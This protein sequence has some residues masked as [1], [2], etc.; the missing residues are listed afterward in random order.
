MRVLLTNARLVTR[1]GSESYLHDV[2]RWLRDNGHVPIVYSASLGAMASLV[3][4]DRIAVVDDLA[5]VAE[6]PDVIHGQHHIATLTAMTFFASVPAVSFCH[7]WLPWEERPLRH[8]QIRRYVAV[9]DLTRE[10][11]V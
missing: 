7:G 2:A 10:R 1:A 5:K 8:P 3:R 4:R 6:P 9:S 11:F